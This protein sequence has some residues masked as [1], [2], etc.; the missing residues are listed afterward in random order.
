LEEIFW[1]KVSEV[2]EKLWFNFMIFGGRLIEFLI[3]LLSSPRLISRT[4]GN[5]ES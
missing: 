4:Y 3:F 5:F 1:E 2:V